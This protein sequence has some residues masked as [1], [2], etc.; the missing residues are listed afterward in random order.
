MNMPE[1]IISKHIP[2]LI[3]REFEK[4]DELTFNCF[5]LRKIANGQEAS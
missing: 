4:I 1:S 5:E 3:L 2:A